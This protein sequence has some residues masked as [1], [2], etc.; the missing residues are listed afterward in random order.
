MKW[1]YVQQQDLH[2]YFVFIP[3]IV[4]T[5]SIGTP[6]ILT[7]LVLKCEKVHSTTY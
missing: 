5:L 6:Y 1:F 7:V 4:F 3:I 2:K